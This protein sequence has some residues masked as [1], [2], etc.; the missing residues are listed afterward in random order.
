VQ[1]KQKSA[2]VADK[3]LMFTQWWMDHSVTALL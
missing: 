1:N 2:V 3:R